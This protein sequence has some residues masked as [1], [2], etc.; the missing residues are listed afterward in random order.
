MRQRSR[1]QRQVLSKMRPSIYGFDYESCG[2]GLPLSLFFCINSLGL[3]PFR[4]NH[5]FNS[6]VLTRNVFGFS[7]TDTTNS[8]AHV[9]SSTTECLKIAEARQ[10][11]SKTVAACT[12]T[13]W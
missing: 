8:A 11:A 12:S 13:E 5:F 9:G 6:T 10:T 1:E 4:A 7:I 3:L 2:V